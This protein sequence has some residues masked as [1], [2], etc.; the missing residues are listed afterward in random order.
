[1]FKRAAHAIDGRGR[2]SEDR[3][4]IQD[5]PGGKLFAAVFDGHSGLSSVTNTLKLLPGQIIKVW[6]EVG[7]DELALRAALPKVFIEHDKTLWKAGPLSYRESGTTATIALITPKH[8]VLAHVGDSPGFV[9][10]LTTGKIVQEI[11]NHVPTRPDERRRILA[12]GGEVTQDEG[13]APRVNGMLMVS[14]AFGDFSLKIPAGGEIREGTD[15]TK[16]FCVTAEP[17]IIVVPRPA[18]GLLAIMS[19][20]LVEAP[21]GGLKP[22]S[23]VASAI[24]TAYLKNGRDVNAVTKAVI[25]DH[26]AEQ[27][28]NPVDYDGDDL[29]LLLVDVSLPIEKNAHAVGGAPSRQ[30]IGVK[31]RRAKRV[32]TGKRKLPKTFTL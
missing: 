15:W 20:G 7:D 23:A 26:V 19:D 32:R 14:R 25:A 2:P 12:N 6:Q 11:Q 28:D 24:H 27:V 9:M 4:T 18:A 22:T 17:D 21:D 3:W 13:D 30:G 31:T 16:D 29:T 5:V 8:V 1:M 10:D